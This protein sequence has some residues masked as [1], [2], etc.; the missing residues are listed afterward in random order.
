MKNA[1]ERTF[2][3]EFKRN[4]IKG[5]GSQQTLVKATSPA[6]AKQKVR[7]SYQFSIKFVQVIDRSLETGGNHGIR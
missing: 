1:K 6:E 5:F 3:V 2:S 7:D 4:D